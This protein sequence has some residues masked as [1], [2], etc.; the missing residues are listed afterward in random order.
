MA[1]GCRYFLEWNRE[2]T[3]FLVSLVMNHIWKFHLRLGMRLS[4]N[5]YSTRNFIMYGENSVLYSVMMK[6]YKHC[7]GDIE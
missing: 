2:T 4:L 5:K 3:I 1:G 6:Y 7:F